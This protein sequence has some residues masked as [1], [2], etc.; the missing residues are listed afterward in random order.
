MVAAL[1]ATIGPPARPRAESPCT[2]RA[3]TSFPAP[4]SPKSSTCPSLAAAAASSARNCH[5]AAL[6]PHHPK[7]ITSPEREL[8]IKRRA[9][10]RRRAQLHHEHRGVLQHQ[11]V[12][13]LHHTL[14]RLDAIVKQRPPPRVPHMHPRTID[15]QRIQ[16]QLPPRNRLRRESRR[17]ERSTGPNLE[18]A[19]RSVLKRA[20]RR[21]RPSQQ[22]RAMRAA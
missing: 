18:E 16:L 4:V 20:Q 21:G 10:E 1:R 2:T 7:P 17:L 9:R 3:A 12:P 8:T 22:A 11:R 13:R 14:L 6:S 19:K 15:R 5:A